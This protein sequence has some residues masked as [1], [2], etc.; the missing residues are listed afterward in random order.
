VGGLH[1]NRLLGK[2]ETGG[3]RAAHL[4]GSCGPPSKAARCATCRP[5]RHRVRTHRRQDRRTARDGGPR[6]SRPLDGTEPA[7]AAD[8]T[9]VSSEAVARSSSVSRARLTMLHRR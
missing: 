3:A 6:C 2:G 8:T 4:D 5:A 7:A 1:Q 9:A